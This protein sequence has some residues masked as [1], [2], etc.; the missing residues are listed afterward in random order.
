MQRATDFLERAIEIARGAGEILLEGY[1][2][3]KAIHHK[4]SIDLVTE[5]DRRSETFIVEALRRNFP[6]HAIRAEEGGSVNG[7]GGYEWLVDP[8]DGTTN[9]AHNFPCFAV[10]LALTQASRAIVAAVYE[11]VHGELFAATRNGGATL[12]GNPIRVSQNTVLEQCMLATGFPYDLRTNPNNNLAEFHAFLLCT[13]AVRRPGA[14]ALDLCYTACG[15]LDGFWE[16]TLHP[17]DTAAG[18]LIVE[19]AGGRVTTAAGNDSWLSQPSIVASN[20]HIHAKM[21]AVLAATQTGT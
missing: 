4:G 16:L 20:S 12:N 21:L 8:L 2:T 7:A 13:Q 11:P 5:F 10:S 14:A 6:D 15:R 3:A 19:E 1:G 18:G 9:F 17:W